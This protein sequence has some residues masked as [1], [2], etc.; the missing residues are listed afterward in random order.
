[1]AFVNVY[2]IISLSFP[3]SF[4]SALDPLRTLE[5][6]LLPPLPMWHF[7]KGTLDCSPLEKQGCV[8]GDKARQ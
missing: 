8:L 1:M 5:T 3:S 7:H 6:E 2:F 4:H